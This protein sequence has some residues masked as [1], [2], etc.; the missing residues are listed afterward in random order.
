MRVDN[1]AWIVP[2]SFG[3]RSAIG[4]SDGSVETG[5]GERCESLCRMF[6]TAGGERGSS[7]RSSVMR[8]ERVV[9][10]VHHWD[11]GSRCENML[12]GQVE[13]GG[14]GGRDESEGRREQQV[15]RATQGLRS[16]RAN[17]VEWEAGKEV[18]AR[19]VKKVSTSVIDPRI[20]LQ[21]DRQT[22]VLKRGRS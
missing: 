15:V 22:D 10:R 18:G 6:G 1:R 4:V 16:H 12:V 19:R 21:T 5:G 17:R 20:V 14:D 9:R 11:L 13:A 3:S 7:V 8:C 2:M